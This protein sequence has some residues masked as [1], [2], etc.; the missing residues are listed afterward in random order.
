MNALLAYKVIVD[1]V[2]GV[3]FAVNAARARWLAIKGFR[4][5]NG[6][7]GYIWH[8]VRAIRIPRYDSSPL[9]YGSQKFLDPG[10][11]EVSIG[12]GRE[13]E[14]IKTIRGQS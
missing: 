8:S 4:K 7:K 3:V 11:V 9:K 5:I 10:D 12:C 6:D 2:T 13:L 14:I 1:D